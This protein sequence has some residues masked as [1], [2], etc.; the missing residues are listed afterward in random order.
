MQADTWGS[1]GGRAVQRDGSTQGARRLGNHWAEA[2]EPKVEECGPLLF[3]GRIV[4]PSQGQGD[5]APAPHLLI[6]LLYTAHTLP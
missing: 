5:S 4:S 6:L 2:R 3:L 1:R